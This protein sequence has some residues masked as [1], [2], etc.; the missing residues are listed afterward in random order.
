MCFE[1]HE[2]S[3]PTRCTKSGEYDTKTLN[4]TQYTK[5][6]KYNITNPKS[7]VVR[8]WSDTEFRIWFCLFGPFVQAVQ[9]SVGH[10]CVVRECKVSVADNKAT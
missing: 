10:T 8:N 5:S 1:C 2:H 4:P 3:E 7:R 9:L 6:G